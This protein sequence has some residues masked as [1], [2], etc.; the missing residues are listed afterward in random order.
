M[1]P[2]LVARFAEEREDTSTAGVPDL[3]AVGAAASRVVPKLTRSV[4]VP[5]EAPARI[6]E[7]G[8][9]LS[10]TGWRSDPGCAIGVA[11]QFKPSGV[12]DESS[13]LQ[14]VE[15]FAEMLR[16]RTTCREHTLVRARRPS[17]RVQEEVLP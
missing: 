7:G 11:E 12:L 3:T 5:A 16:P 9:R 4:A 15:V 8:T 2:R 1:V 10:L 14:P 17:C 6:L 13:V